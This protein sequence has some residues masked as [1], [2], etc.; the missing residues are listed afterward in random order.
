MRPAGSLNNYRLVVVALA[1]VTLI[2][3]VLLWPDGERESDLKFGTPTPT[4]KA[5]VESVQKVE[6][7]VPIEDAN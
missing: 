2:A 6:C 7:T 3:L 1:A 4:E 5:E